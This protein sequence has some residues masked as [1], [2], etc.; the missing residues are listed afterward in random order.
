M[1]SPGRLGATVVLGLFLVG[2]ASA[3]TLELKDGRV[4]HGRYLGGTQAV[5]RFEIN[6]EVQ[7]FHVSETAA[8]TFTGSSDAASAPA[9]AAPPVPAT[10]AANPPEPQQ[11]QQPQQPEQPQQAQEAPPPEAAPRPVTSQDVPPRAA[12]TTPQAPALQA[13]APQAVAGQ[14]SSAQA[15]D[16]AAQYGE[17]T[18]PSG[19]SLLIRMIDGVD[20]A[21]NHVGDVF[22][23]SLETDLYVGNTL[24]AR[25]GA[26]VYGQL[27]NAQQAGHFS[28]SADLQLQLMRIVIDGHDYPLVSSDYNVKGQSRGADTAKK[29]G[30][31]AI[32]GAILGAIAGGG[33]G[34]AI[35]ATAGSAAGAGVQV[36][37]RGQQ[38][39]VPSETLLEF[40]LQQPAVV[41]PTQQ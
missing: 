31:G 16:P 28:G 10:A 23:A 8:L 12:T 17:V 18:I 20:S 36:F 38:V 9:A 35:G 5:L 19:Q 14:A 2:A 39:R 29:V 21:R 34:A 37:T 3:D 4:F 24:V 27:A 6:G 7:T 25:K 26:D 11:A 22:H 15:Q 30:G 32:F 33:R 1:K 13:T 40:R 41:T